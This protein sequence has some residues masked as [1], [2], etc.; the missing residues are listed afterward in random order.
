[1]ITEVM[2]KLKENS[3]DSLAHL[4]ANRLN[5]LQRP[6]A[7]SLLVTPGT[8]CQAMANTLLSLPMQ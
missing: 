3:D 1:M 7:S 2:I 4:Q 8:S 5:D 6:V